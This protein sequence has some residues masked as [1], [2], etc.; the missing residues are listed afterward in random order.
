[1]NF[2]FEK[3][4]KMSDEMECSKAV[5]QKFETLTSDLAVLV[6]VEVNSIQFYL[7]QSQKHQ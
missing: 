3:D 2:L 4:G 1:M 5:Y 7:F 6:F